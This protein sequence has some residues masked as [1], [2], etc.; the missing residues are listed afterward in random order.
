MK[1]SISI[2][3]KSFSFVMIEIYGSPAE[4]PLNCETGLWFCSHVYI[5]GEHL[6]LRLPAH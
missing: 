3:L 2:N 1:I 6:C 4:D 5:P